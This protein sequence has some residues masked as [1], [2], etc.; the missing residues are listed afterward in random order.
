MG[1]CVSVCRKCAGAH[2]GSRRREGT[3][4]LGA[5]VLGPA[6]AKLLPSCTPCVMLLGPASHSKRAEPGLLVAAL[7]QRWPQLR[8]S[9]PE[10]TQVWCSLALPQLQIALPRSRSRSEEAAAAADTCCRILAS[11]HSRQ[12]AGSRPA[13]SDHQIP[14][15][16]PPLRSPPLDQPLSISPDAFWYIL[17]ISYV[18]G[19]LSL[20]CV[21]A[22][23]APWPTT[24]AP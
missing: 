3:D 1:H 11:N 16:D 20:V 19:G 13:L 23:K 21:S 17:L 24:K 5:A 14:P 9:A 4:G 10:G 22:P 6:T 12:E 15:D 2:E 7:P 8:P 18:C